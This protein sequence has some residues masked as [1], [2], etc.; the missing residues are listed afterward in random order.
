M[1]EPVSISAAVVAA[2]SA[3]ADYEQA[4]AQEK[5][6]KAQAEAE[7][8]QASQQVKQ[9]ASEAYQQVRAARAVAA[10]Q[11]AA[12]GAN[13]LLSTSGS[14]LNIL[15]DTYNEGQTAANTIIGNAYNGALST[16]YQQNA[17]LASAKNVGSN[18]VAG[19]LLTGASTYFGMGGKVSNFN[20][21]SAPTRTRK[22]VY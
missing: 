4:D 10:Q 22:G 17:L 16:R 14:A 6:Y 3:Y 18:K 5:S 15:T 20:T 2:V 9:G 7:G 11:D 13:G 8:V 19:S 12:F 1:C 21:S